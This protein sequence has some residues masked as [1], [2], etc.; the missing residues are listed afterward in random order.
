MIIKGGLILSYSSL[1][2]M[3]PPALPPR[4]LLKVFGDWW[5]VGVV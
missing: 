2:G 4:T 3:K 1:T 5:L